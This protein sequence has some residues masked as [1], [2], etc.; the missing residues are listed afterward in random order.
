M[1]GT[2]SGGVIFS[3]GSNVAPSVFGQIQDP[4]YALILR[5]H[6][7]WMN[8]DTNMVDRVFHE[9]RIHTATGSIRT[10]GNLGEMEIVGENGPKP[11][12]EILEGFSKVLSSEEW[13]KSVGISQTA[14]EDEVNGILKEK[15]H[16]LMDAYHR[17]RNSFFWGLFGSALQN[18]N[19]VR[20]GRVISTKT[21][22]DV[23]LFHV[24][25]PSAFNPKLKQTNAYSAVFS[26]EALDYVSTEMQNCLTDNGE[27]A[28]ITPDTIIIPNTAKA[29]RSVFGAIG[30]FYD[31]NEPAGN[32][33][34][35]QF[36]NWTVI[37]VPWLVPYVKDKNSELFPWV[38][39]DSEQNKTRYG[40]VDIRRVDPTI[41][42]YIDDD[43]DT[44]FFGMR[45]RFGG[46]FGDWRAFAAGGLEFGKAI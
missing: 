31:P 1:S 10:M 22:D 17:T 28:G 33:F 11:R 42:S 35:Y 26:A 7:A 2:M 6:E 43:T 27:V 38:L 36:G 39:M 32:K 45:T 19:Y 3:V 34:N 24:A 14:L 46:A 20:N 37:T 13:K 12:G 30:A 16:E 18:S 9:F 21:M 40:A 44:N 23:N 5:E 29:K 8:K 25:H 4:M 41:K 15:A